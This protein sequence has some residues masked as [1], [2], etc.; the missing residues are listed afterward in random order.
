MN[1]LPGENKPHPVGTQLSY[2]F[3]VPVSVATW[4][5]RADKSADSPVRLGF[6]A[7][8]CMALSVFLSLSVLQFLYL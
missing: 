8:N 5:S 7:P 3:G 1:R 4:C 6:Q 2:S